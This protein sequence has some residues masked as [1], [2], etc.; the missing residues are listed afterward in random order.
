MVVPLGTLTG[1]PCRRR[2]VGNI[3][4]RPP[5]WRLTTLT[6]TAPVLPDP[7][8]GSATSTPSGRSGRSRDCPDPATAA[9]DRVRRR[10]R[11]RIVARSMAGRSRT[12]V[13][14]R[15]GAWPGRPSHTASVSESNGFHGSGPPLPVGLHGAQVHPVAQVAVLEHLVVLHEVGDQ[16]LAVVGKLTELVLRTF[17]N[18]DQTALGGASRGD[19]L[20]GLLQG[21]GPVLAQRRE[22][23]DRTVREVTGGYS[24]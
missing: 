2:P 16:V 4:D 9:T 1:P 6:R 3:A 22:H 23:P 24:Q 21:Q 7:V 13:R 5:R 18:G 12:V 14:R 11:R 17:E 15:A 10:S 19:H 8:G 20:H